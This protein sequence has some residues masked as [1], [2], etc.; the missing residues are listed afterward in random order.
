MLKS[1]LAKVL[2]DSGAPPP[3]LTGEMVVGPDRSAEL[4]DRAYDEHAHRMARIYAGAG[5]LTTETG[6]V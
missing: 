1:E 5:P 2:T 3:V 6:D 4:F